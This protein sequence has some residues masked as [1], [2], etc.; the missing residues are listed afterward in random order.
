[1]DT[2]QG[3]LAAG[4][5]LGQS[6]HG[7]AAGVGKAQHTGCLVEA[8]A[9]SV[10]P[11]GSQDRHV[12]IVPDIHD[13]GVAAGDGQRQ[14]GRLQLREGQIVG[15][16][17]ATDVVDRDQRHVQRI[18][19]G[20]G[21]ADPHQHGADETGGIGDGHGVHVA[22]GEPGIGQRLIRQT[23]N[24]LHV[25]AGGDL[26]HYAAVESVHIRLR[27]DGVGEDRASV[28]HH[29]HGGLVAGGFKGQNVHCAASP[30]NRRV[31]IRASS[32]GR[33]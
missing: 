28:P 20:L 9:G 27:E 10:I 24:G 13:E 25:L 11:C 5:L 19:H 29:G 7:L 30:S 32:L 14:K 15:G 33:S 6:V 3:I 12:R 23:G 31:R 18:G 4:G 2:R 22:L 1:M 21:E 26:R 16:D 17:V 8:L